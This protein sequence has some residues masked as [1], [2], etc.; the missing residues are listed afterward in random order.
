[1]M[2]DRT[3]DLPL[4][5]QARLLGL[6]RSTVYRQ[7]DL[8]SATD[9]PWVRQHLLPGNP[10]AK[11]DNEAPVPYIA[12]CAPPYLYASNCSKGA[13]VQNAVRRPKYRGPIALRG[14]GRWL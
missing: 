12:C 14:R 4:A 10:A 1:M 13:E 6:A 7:P 2:I 5:T 9:L 11:N 3:H 8:V